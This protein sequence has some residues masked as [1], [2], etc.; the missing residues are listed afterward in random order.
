MS[1]TIRTGNL[2]ESRCQTLVNTV[3]TVGVMGKGIAAAFKVRFPEMYADYRRR[4]EIQDP[5]D[6]HKVRLGRPYLY[7]PSPQQM[8][9]GADENP[10]PLII[11]FPTKEH[12]RRPSDFEAILEGLD[13]LSQHIAEWGVTSIAVPPLGCGHG[14]LEWRSVGPE[15]YS[16]LAT[17][18]IPVELYA[19][20]G[21]PPS[22]LDEAFL[23]RST[24]QAVGR[25]SQLEPFEAALGQLIG[26]LG[27]SK[28]A[29][30]IT[31]S[32]LKA[33]AYWL[34]AA[35]FP[36]D[37]DLEWGQSGL[38]DAQLAGS[39]LRLVRNAIVRE[40][41][42]GHA[43]DYVAGKTLDDTLRL[44]DRDLRRNHDHLEIARS[45]FLATRTHSRVAPAVHF[46]STVAGRNRD[47]IVEDIVDAG[48]RRSRDK[49][50]QEVRT[51]IGQLRGTRLS[52][53]VA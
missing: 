49:A 18:D 12:W 3:N 17:L 31:K 45:A 35:G 8:M 4:C 19:P 23:A 43:T 33:L 32:D 20:Q 41:T 50:D 51:V 28:A 34:T 5:N 13:Y 29:G 7:A 39:I 15:L 11:N 10:Q 16:R 48:I 53:P 40:R 2:L 42:R 21:T 1:V 37:A 6:P 27:E 9:L 14:G 47:E 38:V 26:S 52:L 25:P 22:E 24:S 44:F 46:L 30:A 36:R